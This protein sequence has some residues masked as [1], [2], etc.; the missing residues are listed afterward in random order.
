VNELVK[1]NYNAVFPPEYFGSLVRLLEDKVD[2]EFNSDDEDETKSEAKSGTSSTPSVLRRG[3][4]RRLNKRSDGNL[5]KA[6]KAAQG[7]TRGSASSRASSRPD[8][9]SST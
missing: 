1:F 3:S 8:C 5:F 7:S 6:F 9:I 2:E 4:T